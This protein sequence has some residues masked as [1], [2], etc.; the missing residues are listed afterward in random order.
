M[1]E[2]PPYLSLK[3]A[4]ELY[5]KPPG[6]LA[7]EE[8]QRLARIAARQVQ[9]EQRILATAEAAQ[10]VLPE[11]SV[12]QGVAEV[13]ARYATEEDFA[14]DLDQAGLD[15]AGLR[16]AIARDLTVEAVL[17]HMA[18]PAAPVSE[19]EVE[20]F[21][22]VHRERFVRPETRTLRH[23]LVTVDNGLA[24]SERD[25][26]RSKI[27][28][29]RARLFKAPERFAAQALRH[30]ECPTAMNGGLLGAVARGQLFPE[31]EPAAFALAPGELSGIVESPLGF[32]L[33]ICDAVEAS[34]QLPL[35]GVRQKIRAHLEEARRKAVQKAWIAGLFKQPA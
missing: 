1:P 33:I 5:R 16:A 34:G 13:R 19:T 31:L 10:V 30:S 23:I 3:L 17:E 32:H 7:A 18:G 22:L 24:G 2:A 28:A 11:S 8:R 26:A 35:A 12:D 25:A 20:I 14:A 21:Y 15:P 27:E 29:I 4:H 6:R 9:I